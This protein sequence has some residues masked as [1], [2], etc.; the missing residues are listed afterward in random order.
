MDR[1]KLVA[2]VKKLNEEEIVD[3][4]D[5]KVKEEELKELFGQA[6]DSVLDNKE[7]GATEEE[8]QKKLPE[9]VR[10]AYKELFLEEEKETPSKEVKKEVAKKETAKKET[11][12]KEKSKKETGKKETPKKETPKKETG[13]PS[14]TEEVEKLIVEGKS[15]DEISAYMTKKFGDKTGNRKNIMVFISN[16]KKSRKK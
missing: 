7:F 15:I 6:V 10:A 5:V 2:V 8:R 12:K 14:K 16:I 3:P 4:I 1:Q 9:E 11:A 13:K